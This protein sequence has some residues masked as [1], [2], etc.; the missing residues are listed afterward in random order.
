LTMNYVLDSQGNTA[1]PLGLTDRITAVQDQSTQSTYAAL[2]YLA[3]GQ[4]SAELLG[5]GVLE[6]LTWNDRLQQTQISV[7]SGNLLALHFYPCQGGV[8]QCS[9]N[10]GNIQ[11]QTIAVPQ[12]G[13]APALNV[14]QTYTYDALNRLTGATETGGTTDWSEQHGYDVW[15]NHWIPILGRTNLPALTTDVPVSSGNI[16]PNNNRLATTSVAYDNDGNATQI[17]SQL[18]TYDAEDRQV[19]ATGAG[20]AAQYVYDG[21]GRRVQKILGS[22][23]T[24]Y[25][26]DAQGQLAAEYAPQ[27]AT[28]DCGTP[29]CYFTEDHL[30]STRLVTD[31]S[32]NVAKRFDYLPFGEEIFAGVGGRTTTEGYLSAPDPLNPKFGG[33]Q[34]DNETGLDFMDA[35]YFS[36]AQGRF[37]I[38]DWSA[39]EEPVP[40]AKLEDPQSLNLYSYVRNNPLSAFDP[41]GHDLTVAP[42]LQDDVD[43]MREQ[44]TAFDDELSAHEGPGSPNL[45]ITSG[46]TPNDPSGLP[47]EGNT[48]GHYGGEIQTCNG[49]DCG[50][51]SDPE[52]NGATVTIN[53]SVMDDKDK[54]QSDLAHEIGHVNDARTHTKKY[55]AESDHTKATKGATK[56][57]NRPEE[58]T[59]EGFRMKVKQQRKEW[60]QAQKQK[61]KEQKKQTPTSGHKACSAGALNGSGDGC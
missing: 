26:Y 2:S 29:T 25:V 8:T 47:A 16:N 22:V 48:A 20:A 44:S 55:K 30:G 40:Y 23:T 53:T 21:E 11:S 46:S 31:T 33:H 14:S 43:D 59:A 1:D 35:R 50:A 57:K 6:N 58:Q 42:A 37:T 34:R 9:N 17:A 28:S 12:I 13:A 56:W 4:L 3:P 49:S 32:G 39:K 41:D 52:Y 54:R 36:S 60:K 19:T 38:P 24:N 61:K 51:P 15:G 7:G 10:N 5:N 45:E 18:M 27:P